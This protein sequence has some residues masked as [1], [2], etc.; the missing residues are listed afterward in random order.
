MGW[1][2][3]EPVDAE[4][5]KGHEPGKT[6][7]YFVHSFHVVPDDL[8]LVAAWATY[9]IRFAAAVRKGHIWG[10]QF[11]PEKSHRHGLNVLRNYVEAV[12]HAV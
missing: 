9:G 10:A 12:R 1:S 3:V 11:H 6:K 4:L 5:F 7:F 8:R 2:E